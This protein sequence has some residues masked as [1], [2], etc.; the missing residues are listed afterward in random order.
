MLCSSECSD[1]FIRLVHPRLFIRDC[2]SL[3]IRDC[4]SERTA[5]RELQK[6]L[7]LD[8][9]VEILLKVIYKT[10][11]TVKLTF[12]F[13][14]GWHFIVLRDCGFL[15]K[16]W[17]LCSSQCSSHLFIPRAKCSS[18]FVHPSV[19]PEQNVHP[20]LF[21]RVFIPSKKCSS[22]K[23]TSCSSR[24][25]LFIRQPNQQYRYAMGENGQRLDPPKTDAERYQRF[26]WSYHDPF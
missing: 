20:S 5:V 15:S 14:D 25:L 17:A 11:H 16:F 12:S 2:S 3:F 18:E 26:L 4:S 13:R 21:I 1:L 23:A 22:E 24:A 6:M 7:C 9:S 8:I 19:H 10:K